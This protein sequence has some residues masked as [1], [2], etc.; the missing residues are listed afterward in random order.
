MLTLLQVTVIVFAQ[1]HYFQLNNKLLR[2]KTC[3]SHKPCNSVM[4]STEVRK[5]D[6]DT[7]PLQSPQI[8][9]FIFQQG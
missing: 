5:Y 8:P 7:A 3:E 9:W 4:E 2:W 1:Y 6:Q